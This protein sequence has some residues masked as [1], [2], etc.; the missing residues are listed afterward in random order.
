MVDTEVVCFLKP[1]ETH[2]VPKGIFKSVRYLDCLGYPP[3]L[4]SNLSH[5]TKSI[6]PPTFENFRNQKKLFTF[7]YL[8]NFY[9]SE[10]LFLIIPI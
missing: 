2:I 7:L 4:Q 5:E 10:Y 3:I 1:M 9:S 6:Y 8:L